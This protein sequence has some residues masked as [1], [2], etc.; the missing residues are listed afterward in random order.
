MKHCK[1]SSV[2]ISP[3]L[4]NP[5]VE[6]RPW[7]TEENVPYFLFCFVMDVL[8]RC[9]GPPLSQ[10][11]L[12]PSTLRFF[13]VL[14]CWQQHSS[15]TVFHAKI[16]IKEAS[17]VPLQFMISGSHQEGPI[18]PLSYLSLTWLQTWSSSLWSADLGVLFSLL[19][20]SSCSCS[21]Q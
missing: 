15:G 20:C 2:H 8:L 17:W 13:R 14:Y 21:H 4:Q 16:K 11:N 10:T 5:E 3:L 9:K 7:Q 6:H 12:Y 18:K 1:T 19:L